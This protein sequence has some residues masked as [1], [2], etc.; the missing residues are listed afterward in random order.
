[1]KLTKTFGL[2]PA[3]LLASSLLQAHTQVSKVVPGDGAVMHAAPAT[4]ELGFSEA[5][6]LLK[7]VV[8]NAAGTVQPVDF[9]PVAK[10]NKVFSIPLPPLV[11]TSYKVSWT[12]LGEDGHKVEGHVGFEV[13]PEAGEVVGT[14]PASGHDHH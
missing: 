8:T 10:A 7:L 5:V 6:Q 9:K 11:P 1:M 2:L 14:V 13:N 12:I 3:L 4:F